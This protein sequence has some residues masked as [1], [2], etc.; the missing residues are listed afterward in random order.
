MVA[1]HLRQATHPWL[2]AWQLQA[3]EGGT[4][5]PGGGARWES[6]GQNTQAGWDGLGARTQGHDRPP[7][8]LSGVSTGG[9]SKGVKSTSIK[10]LDCPQ[11]WP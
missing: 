6:V 8:G 11:S 2:P 1:L 5:A 10:M 4:V 9:G 7:R 3:E